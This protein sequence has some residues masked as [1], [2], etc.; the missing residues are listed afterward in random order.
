M[1]TLRDLAGRLD[2][3]AVTLTAATYEVARTGPA[4]RAFGADAPGWPG[5]L[6]RAL[7][8]QWI[9]ATAARSREAAVA[10]ARLA[11]AATTLRVVAA[12]Y[13]DTDEAAR[14][15]HAGEA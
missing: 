2:E 6:G 8:E 7:Y 10:A 5:E 3:A 15:R 9:S 12:G 13:D 1:E 11:D 14:R 4:P